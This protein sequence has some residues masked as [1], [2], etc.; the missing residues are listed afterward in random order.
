MQSLTQPGQVVRV[1]GEQLPDRET[2]P[3]WYRGQEITSKSGT[4]KPHAAARSLVAETVVG[5]RVSTSAFWALD[6]KTAQIKEISEPKSGQHG[7]VTTKRA[8]LFTR[9]TAY[10]ASRYED[11][12]CEGV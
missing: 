2:R 1:P 5:T 4:S 10:I 8:N 3:T 12:Q 7:L 6:P 9:R 11:G